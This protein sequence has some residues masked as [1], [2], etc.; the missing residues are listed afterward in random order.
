MSRATSDV[1]IIQAIFSSYIISLTGS[2]I[3]LCLS[4]A[5]L[6]NL[7]TR[8][9]L[10]IMSIVPLNLFINRIYMNKLNSINYES[11]EEGAHF[12]SQLLEVLSGMEAVKSHSAE[13]RE[14]KK[15]SGKLRTIYRLAFKN[16]IIE[17]I[18]SYILNNV[19]RV[20]MLAVTWVAAQEVL[21]KAM[22]IGDMTA[23]VAYAAS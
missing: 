8:V 17:S 14:L 10:I 13:D 9:T 16:T 7:N 12:S 2:F 11:S 23:F 3:R 18:T 19:N 21:K 6:F 20:M 15:M 4:M 22:S 5:I 1:N